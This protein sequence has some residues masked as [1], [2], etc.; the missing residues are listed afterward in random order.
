MGS[1]VVPVTGQKPG[2][3][4]SGCGSGG[5]RGRP[6]CIEPFDFARGE[7]GGEVLAD[8][9]LPEPADGQRHRLAHSGSELVGESFQ[10]QVGCLVDAYTDALQG[11]SAYRGRRASRGRSGSGSGRSDHSRSKVSGGY[12][13]LAFWGCLLECRLVQFLNAGGRFHAEGFDQEGAQIVVGAD[14]LGS[15]ACRQMGLDQVGI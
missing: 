14:G 8:A 6:A 1:P 5:G 7:F 12:L 4:A 3:P 9:V 2:E 15:V 10:F 11:D 13:G